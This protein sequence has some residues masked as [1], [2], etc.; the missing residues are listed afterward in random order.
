MLINPSMISLKMNTKS[1]AL[2]PESD[3]LKEKKL[4]IVIQW[5]LWTLT[6]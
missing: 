4:V 1:K 3:T 6:T 2:G 5:K